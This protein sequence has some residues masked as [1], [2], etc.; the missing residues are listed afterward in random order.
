MGSGNG[1]INM[2]RRMEDI[3]GTFMVDSEVGKGTKII[4]EGKI[5]R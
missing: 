2:R 3:N 1:M 4:L 5:Y